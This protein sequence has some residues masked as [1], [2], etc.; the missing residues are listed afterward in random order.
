MTPDPWMTP[1]PELR[2]GA[3]IVG[4]ESVGGGTAWVG[5]ERS[6]E[7]GGE[8]RGEPR[9]PVLWGEG[10]EEAGE[11]AEEQGGEEEDE[12]EE[13]RLLRDRSTGSNWACEGLLG[14][15]DWLKAC[16]CVW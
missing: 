9:L 10:G 12:P 6:W 11:E 16:M 4:Y 3:T 1:V 8:Q 7:C 2:R 15:W 14:V 5:E 13:E